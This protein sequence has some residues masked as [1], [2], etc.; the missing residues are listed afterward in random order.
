MSQKIKVFIVGIIV[1]VVMGIVGFFFIKDMLKPNEETMDLTD[2]YSEQIG[3]TLGDEQAVLILQSEVQSTPLLFRDGEAYLDYNMVAELFNERFYWDSNEKI[4][5]YTLPDGTVEVLPDQTSYKYKDEVIEFEK[6]ILFN[7]GDDVKIAASFVEKY[8]YIEVECFENPNRVIIKND[9]EELVATVNEDTQLRTLGSNKGKVLRELKKGDELIYIMKDNT[10][11][12]KGY[13]R[14]ITQDGILGYV[15]EKHMSNSEYRDEK[16]EDNSQVE[17]THVLKDYEINLTWNMVTNQTANQMVG[18]LLDSA[19][20]VNTISPTWFSIADTDGGI[21]TSLAS[22]DYVKTVHDRG[23]EV[24]ALIDD[25]TPDV[26]IKEILTHTTSRRNLTNNIMSAIKEY[27]LDGINID[28]EYIKE[29]F[30]KDYIQFIRELSVECRKEQVVLSIDSYV[31]IYSQFYN[32]AEQANVADYVIIMAYDEHDSNSTK[33]GSVASI[34]WIKSAIDD[35]LEQISDPK[36]LVIAIPFYDRLWEEEYNADGSTTLIS[37]KDLTMKESKNVLAENE[38]TIKWDDE[39]KQHY[40]EY[41]KGTHIFKMW[42]EDEKSVEEKVKLIN[43][44]EIGGIAS[45]RLGQ[46]TSDVWPV[47]NKYINK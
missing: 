22:H 25:F 21:N 5:L 45:W 13:V 29:S 8:S 3:S 46:E 17:Y 7:E 47:I 30:A 11:V 36:Q 33:S 40:A 9:W 37:H 6:T 34:S 24:W 27:K 15:K 1:F 4:L 20:G 38:A 10:D 2:Y 28:F 19:P 35:T 42:L 14:A 41:K 31:P 12:S 44:A 23:V 18:Q 32:R 39:T 26:S 16:P 43:Q